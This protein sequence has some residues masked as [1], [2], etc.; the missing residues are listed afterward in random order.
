[1]IYSY[2]N[3]AIWY[4]RSSILFSSSDAL[5]FAHSIVLA[6]ETVRF[7]CFY[8]IY[9]IAF[10]GF[11]ISFF[12][13]LYSLST[14]FTEINSSWVIYESIKAITLKTSIVFNFA[15]ANNTIL[16]YFFL[17]F[18]ND[19]YFWVPAVN[20]QIFNYIAELAIPTER[21]TYVPVKQMQKFKH[22]PWHQKE[23]QENF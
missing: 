8:I 17:F 9:S 14:L 13:S 15:F 2:N 4:K 16:L 5:I 18:L 7:H 12:V 6:T 20:A 21:P 10:L 11:L 1:M 3:R 23:K 19:L 22:N